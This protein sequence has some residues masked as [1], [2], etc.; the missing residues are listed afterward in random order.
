M[1]NTINTKKITN[2]ACANFTSKLRCLSFL[3]FLIK[4]ILYKVKKTRIV[5]IIT[6]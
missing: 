4:I 6:I 5:S 1:R 3:C 2:P